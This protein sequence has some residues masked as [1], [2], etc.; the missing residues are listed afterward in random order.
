M[1]DLKT[2]TPLTATSSSAVI[3]GA[4]STAAVAP[5]PYTQAA[6]GGFVKGSIGGTPNGTK[7][8][9]DDWTWAVASGGGGTPGGTSGQVQVNLTGSFGGITIGGDATL[10]TGTGALTVTKTSGVSF[11]A[12]A[13]VTPG[14]GIATALGVAVG[15]AG[16]PVILGGALGTP[17][18]GALTNC[19]S[20]PVAN[21]T[22]NL[23]VANLGSGTSASSTTYWR[24][25]G[26]WA[27]PPGGSASPGG[28]S[29]QFQYNN[30][31]AFGGA[32][33]WQG[34]NIVSQR[35]AANAQSFEVYNTYTDAS[36][37]ERFE[38]LWS[39]NTL[40][41]RNISAGTGLGRNLSISTSG[42][43]ASVSVSAASGGTLTL[44]GPSYVNIGA[45]SAQSWYFDSA[46]VFRPLTDN[47]S[48]IGLAATNRPR[49]IYSS[50]GV[51]HAAPT[52]KTTAYSQTANDYSLIF[53][54]T[55]SITLTLLA[56]ASYPGKVLYVSNIAA[57]TVVSASSNVVPQ[58]GS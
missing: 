23:P 24:G 31:A 33:L 12:L 51:S 4:E 19:T 47:A 57:F 25:D 43:A 27:T 36:N 1:T 20:V 11:G 16:A 14:T 32:N 30:A 37:Y 49:T 15:S 2:T 21:A 10:D 26:T 13:T 34:T 38:S 17:A 42:N 53:N 54:G 56:A 46:G 29:G 7:V 39:G 22:G 18:S 3:F 45:A 9:R 58:A 35:N 8:L 5:S 48:D 40:F 50:G 41:L 55:A 44:T 52:T 28:S 6:I